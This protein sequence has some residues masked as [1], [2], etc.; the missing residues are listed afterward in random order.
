ENKYYAMMD[1]ALKI[2]PIHSAI[3]V[4]EIARLVNDGKH[5]FL[6]LSELQVILLSHYRH[7]YMVLQAYEIMNVANNCEI[8]LLAAA[9]YGVFSVGLLFQPN[10]SFLPE[11]NN[12][13]ITKREQLDVILNRYKQRLKLQ[14]GDLGEEAGKLV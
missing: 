6:A 9:E 10:S 5:A 12:Q 4:E 7:H 13:I 2:N 3:R 8:Q 1:D 11:T 14:C